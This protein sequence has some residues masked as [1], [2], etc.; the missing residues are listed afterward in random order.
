MALIELIK[1]NKSFDEKIIL[2]NANFSA[3]LGDK[4]AIIGKNG[5]G[6][7]SLMKILIGK[8]ALDSGRIN[9]QNNIKISMLKQ[10]PDFS[11]NLNVIE[12]I[13][14]GLSEI[15]KALNEY[16]LYSKRLEKEPEN[17]LILK[18]IDELSAFLDAKDAWD[19]EAKIER[20][21]KEFD[22]LKFKNRS[23]ST[24]S[25]GEL[26]RIA[27]CQIV[28]ESADIM[29]L[30]E[31]SN[32]LDVYMTSFLEDLLKS[33]KS[34]IIFI[35]HDRYFI[36]EVASSC[37]ELECGE[38][39]NFKGNYTNYL[40]KKAELLASLNKSYESLIKNLKAEEEWLRRGVK[41]R[42][43]RNE[44]RKERILKMREEAKK[45]PSQ[46][47]KLKL[48]LERA[49]KNFNQSEGKNRQKML[50]ELHQISKSVSEKDWLDE[51]L[52][53]NL[54]L[55]FNENLSLNSSQNLNKNLN[56][57]S[58]LNINSN[59]NL[60]LNA[61]QISSQRWL[62][63]NFSV[64]I[65]QNERI[66]IVGAN[67]CG[68]SSFVKALLGLL[69]L[70]SGSIKKAELNIGYFEQT[71]SV[72]NT[73]KTLLE[74][75]CPNGGDTV[76]VWGKNMHLYAYLKNFLFPKEFLQKSVSVL[77]GGEKNRVALAL[78]FTQK[79]DVLILDEPTNDL[80]IATINILEEY[81]LSFDGAILL[82]SHDRFF[83]DK[84][85]TKL[86]AFENSKIEIYHT[87]YTQYLEN[88]KEK[89]EFELF[90][91]TL[92]ENLKEDKSFLKNKTKN[93]KLS[94]K[95]K[96]ILEKYPEKIQNL[97]L[98]IKNLQQSLS[99]EKAYKELSTLYKSLQEAQA[100]L[101][102]LE[103]EYFEVLEKSET[104]E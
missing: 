69:K 41:A 63:K 95:E 24:L 46:I 19:I 33:S 40:S 5:E 11:S 1:A 56:Q 6:K 20:I 43:K 73:D 83:L 90:T 16:E 99:D 85:T 62:F 98:E 89:K 28:L 79:Y 88:E 23:L 18:Q 49:S 26:R 13:K 47:K 100:R 71:R 64:R 80:D 60:K 3:N 94:Y 9:V 12:S 37:L 54:P 78:L 65:M 84:I 96:E 48:E 53:S 44:G 93:I 45:N 34:C 21:L 82:I 92:N 68:K 72:L 76:Q 87:P 29:L 103:N 66:G 86:Y 8:L 67:G 59:K 31:P 81:L 25:G 101:K 2:K 51:N 10:E 97:E 35:S 32:H 75:F 17:K 42:L 104:M 50:F 30:D 58:N 36:D 61:N 52:K 74:L 22:L 14:Q 27:L 38:L 57:N 4:I 77:S 70:D 39:K 102:N 55:N 7:S 15:Y 91:E